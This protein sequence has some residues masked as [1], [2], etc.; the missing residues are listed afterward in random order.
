MTDV[1]RAISPDER[2]TQRWRATAGP[3][4]EKAERLSRA[5]SEVASGERELHT[6]AH[7][8]VATGLACADANTGD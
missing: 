1:I 6:V 3:K 7:G 2:V 8:L 5:L 4:V